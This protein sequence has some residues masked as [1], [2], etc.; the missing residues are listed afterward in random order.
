MNNPHWG[1]GMVLNMHPDVGNLFYA[2]IG[3]SL[4]NQIN[5]L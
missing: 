2:V 1:I 5:I 4:Y 3:L